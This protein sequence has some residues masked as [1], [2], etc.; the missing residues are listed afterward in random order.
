MLKFFV[1]VFIAG[2]SIVF[3]NKDLVVEFIENYLLINDGL[4]MVNNDKLLGVVVL[5][6]F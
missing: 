5:N 6:F 2:I 3:L 4:C 1:G